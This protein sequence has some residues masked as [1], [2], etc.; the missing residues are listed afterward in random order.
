[1]RRNADRLIKGIIKAQLKELQTIK[2]A[3]EGIPPNPDVAR[4]P[5]CNIRAKQQESDAVVVTISHAFGAMGNEIAH[6]L[7]DVL[8]LCC[9]DSFYSKGGG[10][11]CAC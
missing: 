5:S 4:P 6:R 1:M 9:C 7:A 10:P 11:A 8:E 2:A 3:K